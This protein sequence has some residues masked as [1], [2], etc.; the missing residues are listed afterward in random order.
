MNLLAHC[1]KVFGVTSDTKPWPLM[2]GCKIDFIFFS[3][4][5]ELAFLYDEIPEYFSNFKKVLYCPQF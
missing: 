1:H 5:R 3:Y 4:R 2:F